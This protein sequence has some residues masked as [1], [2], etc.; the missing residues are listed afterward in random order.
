MLQDPIN[1]KALE[2][3]DS[4]KQELAVNPTSEDLRQMIIQVKTF[5]L[6]R[7]DYIQSI[8]S[9][10]PVSKEEDLSVQDKN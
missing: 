8:E 5:I 7:E 3:F 1:R 4:L 10:K 9:L 6:F 2:I